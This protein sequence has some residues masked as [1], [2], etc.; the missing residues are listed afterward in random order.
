MI[1]FSNAR[2]TLSSLPITHAWPT[3][4]PAVMK[5]A[6]G[7]GPRLRELVTIRPL[8]SIITPD[9]CF[10]PNEILTIDGSAIAVASARVGIGV[11]VGVGVGGGGV[12]VGVGGNGV[13]VGG[14]G[15]GVGV[16]V[17]VA[18]GSAVGV[19]GAGVGIDAGSLAQAI[20]RLATPVRKIKGN[21]VR[22][23]VM[24]SV[25]FRQTVG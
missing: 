10:D 13:G 23:R 15:V 20:N 14:T 2:S 8:E 25:R 17:G 21:N 3:S 22:R 11:A 19:G 6:T 24:T 16:G 18:V 5:S 9:Q 7:A 1:T 12:G 4:P